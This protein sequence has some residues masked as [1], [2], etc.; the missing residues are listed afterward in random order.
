MAAP[1]LANAQALVTAA[2]PTSM[3]NCLRETAKRMRRNRCWLSLNHPYNSSTIR[4]L[5]Q[6]TIKAQELGEYIACS[7]PLHL[8]DGWDYL[9]RAFDASSR[10]DRTTAYHLAYYAELRAA[11]SLLAT[12]GIGIF[13]DCHVALDMQLTP[14]IMRGSTHAVT[15]LAVAA[16]SQQPGRAIRLL[17]GIDVE[18]KNLSE[19][20]QLIGSGQSIQGS[21]A[22][23]WLSAWSI[24]LQI[25]SRDHYRR[26]EM[27][28]R[29]T[30]IRVPASRPV[31][32]DSE[33][34]GPLFNAWIELEP[35]VSGTKATLDFAFLREAIKLVVKDGNC[36]YPTYRS[37][38]ESLKGSMSLRSYESLIL[39]DPCAG[40]IFRAAEDQ[41]SRRRAVP[42]LARSLLMLR[43]ASASTASLLKTADVSKSDLY[44]WWSRLGK[45]L[46]FWETASD[47]ESF[48]DLWTDVAEAKDRASSQ[49]SALQG[50]LSVRTATKILAQD[51]SITQ[52]S[53]APLWLLG[54]E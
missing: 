7:A 43:I 24:D 39:G 54:L 2:S 8:A 16:W 47:I 13:N 6:S 41:S 32:S 29:P 46:G 15:W 31:D 28:Y 17:Q 20:L 51:V 25:L 11:M 35:S 33:M 34:V 12:E 52:F 40:K 9:S 36:N 1:S 38:I 27:S 18:Y 42:I 45:D 53:R 30:R 19:W 23:K 50:A 5:S 37:A 22:D 14:T 49:M 44:F 4:N 10:G 3:V 48:E 26:N 21:I